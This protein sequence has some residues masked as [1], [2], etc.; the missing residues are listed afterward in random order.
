MQTTEY[1]HI[2]LFRCPACHGALTSICFKSESNLEMA[3]EHVFRPACD[4]GW[5]GE[6]LGFMA[7]RHWVQERE[8]EVRAT[9]DSSR[10]TEA[11]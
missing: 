10:S 5:T 1:A 9:A 11:A 7:V 8:S 3:D 4:C 6:L 2:F